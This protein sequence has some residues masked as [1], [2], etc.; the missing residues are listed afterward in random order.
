MCTKSSRDCSVK[1]TQTYFTPSG[2]FYG[3]LSSDSTWLHWLN[4]CG[5]LSSSSACW[6]MFIFSRKLREILKTENELKISFYCFYIL[7]KHVHSENT[8]KQTQKKI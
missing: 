8:D 6:F 3:F 1:V 5:W 4:P 7:K 2:K